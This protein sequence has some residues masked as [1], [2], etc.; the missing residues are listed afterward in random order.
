MYV[1]SIELASRKNGKKNIVYRMKR[2]DF[3]NIEVFVTRNTT[4]NRLSHIRPTKD[5]EFQQATQLVMDKSFRNGYI[6]KN[7]FNMA[8]EDGK[9]LKVHVPDKISLRIRR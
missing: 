3:L 1:S 9:K 4:K 8:D 2:E 6:I 7:A 5:K